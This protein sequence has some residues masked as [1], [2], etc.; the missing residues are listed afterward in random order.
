MIGEPR[1]VEKPPDTWKPPIKRHRDVPW[2]SWLYAP[3]AFLDWLL[4]F[5]ERVDMRRRAVHPVAPDSLIGFERATYREPSI[6]LRDHVRL[7][8][9]DPIVYLH[10]RNDRIRARVGRGW[11]IESRRAV[12][13]DLARVAAWAGSQQPGERPVAI[14]ATTIL[15]PLLRHEGWEIRERRNTLRARVDDWFERWLLAHWG[16][17]GRQRLER[18]RPLV[19]VDAWL[20]ADAFVAKY[21]GKPS[22]A[23]SCNGR[24]RDGVASGSR[25]RR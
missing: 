22:L 23:V 19:S 14:R 12:R 10:F 9:G 20:S 7:G 2:R 3:P 13:R 1:R 24:G 8:P 15:G 16:L 5:A 11:N 21:G 17:G 4:A 25:P 6:A 18:R